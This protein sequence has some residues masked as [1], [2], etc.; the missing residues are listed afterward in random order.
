M[1]A[2]AWDI[3]NG[4]AGVRVQRDFFDIGELG[5]DSFWASVS[6]FEVGAL[7]RGSHDVTFFRWGD[8]EIHWEDCVV[9]RFLRRIWIN[10]L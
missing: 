6:G 8:M 5:C 10:E 7:S 9:L 2:H 1:F 3:R 4:I